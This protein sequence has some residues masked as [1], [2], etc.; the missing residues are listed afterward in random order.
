MGKLD[1]NM[2]KI[3]NNVKLIKGKKVRGKTWGKQGDLKIG[4]GELHHTS[5]TT[6]LSFTRIIL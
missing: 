3:N 1:G 5:D 6:T 4:I 2:D